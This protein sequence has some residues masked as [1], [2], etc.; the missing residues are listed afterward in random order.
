MFV[1][2]A[3]DH[4]GDCYE[5]LNMNTKRIIQTRD[6]TWLG[7][8]YFADKASDREE[9]I[10]YD[11]ENEVQDVGEQTNVNNTDEEN[12]QAGGETTRSGRQIKPPNRLIEE[13]EGVEVDEIMAVGAG[14]GGGFTHTSELVPMKYDQAMKKDPDGWSKAVDKEHERMTEH[15]V[16]RAVPRSMVPKWAKILTSTWAMKQKADGTL[17]ARINARGFEQ[18]AGEHYKEDGISSPVVN[19]ASIF[20]ILILLIMARMYGELNDVKGAFLNGQFSQGEKLYMKVPQ[21]FEKFY[22]GDV[23]LLLLKTIY[24]LKQAAFEYWRALLKALKMV[25]LERSKAD[26]CVY[27]KWTEKGIMIWSSW[28]DDILSCGNKAEVLKGREAL[29]QHFDLDEIGE[30]NEYVGCKINYNQEEGW[31]ELTQPVLLQSFGDE[32][33]LPNQEYNTP[34]APNS[35]LMKGESVMTEERHHEYRKGVGKLIHYGKYSRPGILNAIREL[36]RFA[37]RPSEAHQ[38]AMLRVMKYCVTNNKGLMLKPN[39]QWDGK[40]K[41]F[42]FEITGYSDS[43]FAKD[44]ETRR[45][46]SGWTAMLNGAP[47]TRKSKMQ[48]FVTLSVTEAECV[49]AT[50]CVQDM[51]Y[52]KRF[53]ESLGLKPKLPMTLYMDNKGGVDIFNNWSIAGNTRAVS[54]RF[55]YIRELKEAGILQIKWIRSEENVADIFTK[56]L[57]GPTY[58]QHDA[59]FTEGRTIHGDSAQQ[60]DRSKLDD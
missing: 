55:A 37:S 7:R 40:D 5:M 23:L 22:P 51:M 46:V 6:V 39:A 4:A 13:I 43:D 2:Y 28:V 54:I 27:F 36:S 45:S 49:A 38:K 29:K 20:I 50:S 33:E 56:N 30:I 12:T 26:P 42:P 59:V 58:E 34:A 53:L 31:M 60:V 21:G 15:A 10:M 41:N 47:Y 48:R 16:W 18:S 14:I 11:I 44:P 3:S 24:G 1:G 25:G 57:D 17:R 19:E 8:M 52:G 32:F 35:L 9:D